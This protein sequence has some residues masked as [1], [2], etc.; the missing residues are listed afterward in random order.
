MY[1]LLTV[2]M[3]VTL[4]V[5]STSK[6]PRI[7]LLI[8]KLENF[9]NPEEVTTPKGTYKYPLGELNPPYPMNYRRSE[10]FVYEI[11]NVKTSINSG[12]CSIIDGKRNNIDGTCAFI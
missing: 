11:E 3:Y 9:W 10:G 4:S 6:R 1:A 7:V 5:C 12:T 8:F 2:K